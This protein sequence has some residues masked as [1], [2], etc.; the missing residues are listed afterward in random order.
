MT[1]VPANPSIYHITHVRNLANIVKADGLWSDAKRIELGFDSEIIGFKSIKEPRLLL[2]VSCHTGTRV[3]E[4]VPFYFCPRS[5]MLYIFWRNNHLD[6]TYHGG[7]GPIVHLRSDMRSV[8]E[9][10]DRAG[11]RW[12]F[13]DKNARA[14]IASFYSS[15]DSLG[16]INWKAVDAER[17]DKGVLREDKQAEFLYHEFFPW[18]LVETIGV[19]DRRIKEQVEDV[20]AGVG[21]QPSVRIKPGWYY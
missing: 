11:T 16:E 15:L 4:Y 7:Q 20:L 19:K 10:A 18:E 1:G 17:W 12:A 9:W 3:G 2:D 8:V 5:E 21:H 6:L 13:T 14:R